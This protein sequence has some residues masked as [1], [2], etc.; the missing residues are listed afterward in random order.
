MHYRREIDGLRAVAVLSVVLFHAGIETFAGGFVGVDVFFVISGYLIT[1]LIIGEKAA[2]DFSFLRFYERRARRILPALFLVIAVTIPVAWLLLLPPA[3]KD[4][5]QSVGY[6][7]FFSSNILFWKQNGYFDTAAELK[8]LLHTWSLAV[9]EQYYLLFPLVLLAFL[10]KGRRWAVVAL[11]ALCLASFTAAQIGSARNPVKAFY[12]LTTRGWEMLIGALLALHAF[13]RS[14]TW[15]R[16]ETVTRYVNE[17]AGLLGLGLIALAVLSFDEET[18]FPGIYALVPTIGA[19]LIILCASPETLVGRW[20]GWRLPVGIG[21]ISYS[22]YLWHQPL[23]ALARVSKPQIAPYELLLLAGFAGV[24]AY[25]S[26]RYMERPFRNGA[27]IGRK[28]ILA[29]SLAGSVLLA[30]FG[31]A[32]HVT[33]GFAGRYPPKD[34]S[35]IAPM[36]ER[37]SYVWRRFQE[38]ELKDFDPRGGRR[39]LVVGDSFSGDLLNAL[40]ES[41]LDKGLQF[42]TYRVSASCGNLYLDTDLSPKVS[43]KDRAFCRKQNWYANS[44]LH[45]LMRQADA[46]WLISSWNSWQAKLV[47]QSKGNLERDFGR[48]VLVFGRKDLG[49]LDLRQMLFLSE[50]ERIALRIPMRS[51]HVAV[52]AAMAKMLGRDFVDLSMLLCGDRTTCRP[53]TTDGKLISFDGGH[54]TEDGARY[55]GQRLTESP[56]TRRL[57]GLAD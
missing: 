44:K 3:M 32:G 43:P 7:S 24:L 16:S 51:S 41:G 52:N 34:Q 36:D 49:V 54:L 39:V 55:L 15:A 5:A 40:H 57:M 21:L 22:F 12:L 13:N 37:T 20:L 2:G 17:A 48:K 8:P 23:F 38:R 42:S 47:P 18:P 27:I 1:S 31:W 46:I 10:R 53:F 9:E 28:Q 33:D 4:F 11:A 25:L 29:F 50:Q 6:V 14:I 26:W 35:L 56:E 30:L 19:G 45:E